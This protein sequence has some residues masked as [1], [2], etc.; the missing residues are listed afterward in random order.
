M[1]IELTIDDILRGQGAD[2]VKIGLRKPAL[3]RMAESAL[4]LGNDQ[5][6]PRTVTKGFSREELINHHAV[7]RELMEKNLSLLA[8]MLPEAESYVLA[9]C[10]IGSDLENLSSKFMSTDMAL[11]MAL[12]GMANAAIDRLVECVFR[13]L[14]DKAE[15]E[16]LGVSLPVSPGSHTWPLEVG[17]PFIF[18]ALDPDPQMVRLTDHFLMLPRKSAS[19]VLGVGPQVKRHGKTCDYCSKVDDCRFRIR[20]TF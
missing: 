9:I 2:P 17:Q 8:E 5:I 15:S 12:D 1:N 16:G 10:T 4:E 3:L 19:F 13:D 18:A 14:T 11:A 20:K 7:P 6:D